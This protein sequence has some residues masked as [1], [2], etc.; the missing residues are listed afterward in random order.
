MKKSLLS[1]VI[2]ALSLLVMAA[3]GS[4]GSTSVNSMNSEDEGDKITIK[5]VHDVAEDH[6]KGIGANL[7]KKKVEERLSDKVNVEVYPNSSLFEVEE[8]TEA[9]QA[10]NVQM[11]VGATSKLVGFDPAYQ[12]LDVPF[13][14]ESG[15]QAAKFIHE[16]EGQELLGKLEDYDLKILDLW[17]GASKQIT[18]SKNPIS[19]SEDLEG[20][21]IRVMAGGLLEDQYTE[22]GAGATIIPFGELYMALQQGVV[23]GQENT[24][25]EIATSNLYEVQDYLTVTN[26]APASYPVLTN[27][28]FWEELPEEVRTELDAIMEEVGEE[29]IDM[30]AQIE[31][32]ALEK[33]QESDIEITELT[34]ENREEFRQALQPLYDKYSDVIGQELMEAA[35]NFE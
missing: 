18:N 22:I 9:L 4:K 15:E 2:L 27:R 3:C 19:K 1:I 14:F 16:K 12:L 11:V 32:E 31:Q 35:L 26:H 5:I 7:I 23:D 33:I 29:V 10:G 30:S 25:I 13:L 34:E 8:G 17:T 6:I 21:K 28:A 20:L 24:F